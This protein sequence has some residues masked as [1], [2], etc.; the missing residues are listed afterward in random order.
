[1]PCRVLDDVAF[2]RLARDMTF[3][4]LLVLQLDDDAGYGPGHSSGYGDEDAADASQGVDVH[5]DEE[6]SHADDDASCLS[7]RKGLMEKEVGQNGNPYGHAVVENGRKACTQGLHAYL[8]SHIV[9]GH[10]QD[11]CY[12]DPFPVFPRRQGKAEPDVD[13][14]ENG[15]SQ[16]KAVGYEESWWK[17]EVGFLH[18]DPVKAPQ[19]IYG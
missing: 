19:D 3:L 15:C 6:T 18:D 4:Y 14:E 7:K 11:S 5:E 12:D 10:L 13:H 2:L 16:G 8:D 17:K 9:E 1:M